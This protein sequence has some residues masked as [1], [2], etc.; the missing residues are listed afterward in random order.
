MV[1][2]GLEQTDSGRGPVCGTPHYVL[3]EDSA[4]P[5]VLDGRVD[6]DR[7][8]AGDRRAFIQYYS[9]TLS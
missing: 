5:M 3:H 6:G 9:R 4:Y 2:S 1:V 7:A 8:D